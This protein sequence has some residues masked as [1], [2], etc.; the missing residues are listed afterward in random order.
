MAAREARIEVPGEPGFLATC[1]RGFL[2]Q[3]GTQEKST[4]PMHHLL[5]LPVSPNH[6]PNI[7]L[8]TSDV[9]LSYSP[10]EICPM[11]LGESP[12]YS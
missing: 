11:G 12:C 1:K 4:Q 6:H 9:P 2:Q 10:F 8:T 7:T 5:F 3:W